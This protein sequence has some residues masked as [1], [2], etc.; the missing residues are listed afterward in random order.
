MP[1]MFQK[2]IRVGGQTYM[3]YDQKVMRY[4]TNVDIS[5][6]YTNFVSLDKQDFN[7][8]IQEFQKNKN[9]VQL[10]SIEQKIELKIIYLEAL[11]QV[12]K[13]GVFLREVDEVI[14]DS[15]RYHADTIS[16]RK[17]YE[18]LL[19]KKSTALFHQDNLGQAKYIA[20]ELVKINPFNV[21]HKALLTRIYYK[22][23]ESR[24]HFIKVMC[25]FLILSAALMYGSNLLV[26]RPFYGDY[27]PLLFDLG[28]AVLNVGV[29]VYVTSEMLLY[30][31]S[32]YQSRRL[33]HKCQN[34]RLGKKDQGTGLFN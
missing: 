31:I 1:K 4:L 8:I 5:N 25:L 23:K 3:G 16:N 2:D 19:L 9:L 18:D 30:G 29:V 26:V 11:Y 12:G 20:T 7:V 21:F 6:F 14:E 17:L 15:I 13:Y 34:H 10:L 22:Q 24:F 28:F 27:L 32:V 33:V